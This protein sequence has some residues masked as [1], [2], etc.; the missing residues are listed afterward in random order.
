[1]GCHIWQFFKNAKIFSRP[2]QNRI[3]LNI[4]SLMKI[5]VDFNYMPKCT[6]DYKFILVILCE[7]CNFMIVE[8][9]KTNK[10][11][12]VC[13]VLIKAFIRYFGSPTP[14]VIDQDPAFMSNLCQY[15]FNAFGMKLV[16]VSPTNH[17]SL[18]AEHGIKS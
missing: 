8:Y 7:V 15:F 2:F 11:P 12:V 5:T 1:M 4:S 17:K 14:I 6:S 13:K 10:A 9:T 18:I 16:T 3:D